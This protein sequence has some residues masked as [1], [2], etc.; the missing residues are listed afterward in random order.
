[1]VISLKPAKFY[2]SSLPRPQIYTDIKFNEERVDPPLSILDPLLDWAKDAH[3][4]MGGLSFK[5]VRHQGKI[6]GNI[7][8]LRVECEKRNVKIE[9]KMEKLR[10]EEE[11]K[12][13][14]LRNVEEE[15]MVKKKNGKGKGNEVAESTR[16][17]K[18][19]LA[20]DLSS[21]RRTSPRNGSVSSTVL[22][23]VR[24]TSPRNGSVSVAVSVAKKK[25][26]TRQLK[27][28]RLVLRDEDDDEV[29]VEQ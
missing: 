12:I 8:K 24:R 19:V 9:A 25:E 16:R 10:V 11:E 14:K 28:R 17:K 6:E 13:E 18:L 27:R 5:R 4:S 23:S 2:G 22:P 26:V 20:T 1:M 3:W 7:K 21:V 29:E 15:K